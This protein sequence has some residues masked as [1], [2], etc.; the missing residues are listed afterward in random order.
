[1]AQGNRRESSAE[2][3][4]RLLGVEKG[5][6]RS[7]PSEE[8]LEQVRVIRQRVLGEQQVV[9]D[10]ARAMMLVG[11]PDAVDTIMRLAQRR[12]GTPAL[13]FE[14]A[15]YVL[16]HAQAIGAAGNSKPLAELPLDQLE[17]VLA[18]ALDNA[19]MLR[20]IASTAQHIDSTEDA[21]PPSGTGEA[22]GA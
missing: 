15:K 22:P 1:M 10:T 5:E 8:E 18:G 13:Q 12:A 14:A 3:V 7:A 2:R 16:E 4:R 6:V 9:N 20:A 11:V 19:R 17:S 21:L